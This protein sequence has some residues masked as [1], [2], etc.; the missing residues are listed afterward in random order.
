[1]DWAKVILDA[2]DATVSEV[3]AGEDVAILFSGGLDSGLLAALARRHGR[4]HLYTV[5][6]EDSH[7]M[8][9]SE[10]AAAYLDLPWTP[11][12]MSEEDVLS[13]SHDILSIISLDDPV[14]LSFEL[15]LQMI[16]SRA[17][18]SELMTGQGA[19]ELFAGYHRYLTMEPDV[20]EKAL[21]NDL[22]RLL[23]EVTPVDLKI[24]DHYG[25][26]LHRPFCTQVIE[27]SRKFLAWR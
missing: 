22:H 2:L 14:M 20:L 19:D 5:G 1:M 27:V 3:M 13:A 16:A 24:C 7:D 4:P 15:P 8:R 9:M 17:R 26:V 25:K 18:E 10:E 12:I 11:L 6:I 21:R 23:E